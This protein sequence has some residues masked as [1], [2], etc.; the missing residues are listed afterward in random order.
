[1]HPEFWLERWREGRIGFHLEDVN[2]RL[3][4]HHRR[5]L[6]EA[7][8][9]L[10]PL[11]GKSADLAWLSMQGHEVVGVELSELAARAFFAE[12]NLE[13]ERREF[14]RFIAYRHGSVTILVGDFFE[15]TA[16]LTGFCEGAYDRAAM[17]ALPEAL[18]SRYAAHLA[19]LL[20]PKARLLLITLDYDAE[21]GP[22]FRVSAEEVRERYG[23]ATIAELA[24]V[25]ARAEMPGVIAR[26]ATFVNETA[27][28]IEFP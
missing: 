25:D 11:C 8:R 5:S 4:D 16:E 7:R 23:T 22:P 15:L 6:G 9:V 21:G 24:R 2:P 14:L 27:F 3:A 26:G 20:A 1:M 19:T 13:P 28:L 12:R 10:V 17:I 18:R